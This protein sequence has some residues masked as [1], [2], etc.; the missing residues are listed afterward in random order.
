MQINYGHG[1]TS[2]YLEPKACHLQFKYQT[3]F[4]GMYVTKF[5]LDQ[6]IFHVAIHQID[7]QNRETRLLWPQVPDNLED[8]WSLSMLFGRYFKI[9]QILFY[10]LKMYLGAYMFCMKG[11]LFNSFLH[12][13]VVDQLKEIIDFYGF[14][15]ISYSV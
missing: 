15:T 8:R 10:C 1:H 5:G 7:C 4:S 14:W 6:V 11:M 12:S 9:S 13:L 2:G 3:V